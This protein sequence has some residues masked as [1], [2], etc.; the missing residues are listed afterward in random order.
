MALSWGSEL[1][2]VEG[3]CPPGLP[4]LLGTATGFGLQS[5]S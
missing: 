3:V 5:L 1:T 4:W 2:L